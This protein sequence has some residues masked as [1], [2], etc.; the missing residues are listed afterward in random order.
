MLKFTNTEIKAEFPVGTVV[1]YIEVAR[2]I[3]QRID[4]WIKENGKVVYG[5]S[6]MVG[7]TDEVRLQ[8]HTHKALL[9][10][11]EPIE[12]CKH[13]KEKVKL[14]DCGINYECECGAQV[15]PAEFKEC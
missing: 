6:G 8:D 14:W 11:I 9:I 1:D 5:Y 10:N 2:W 7:G 13:P 15:E 12:K 3:N 4:N